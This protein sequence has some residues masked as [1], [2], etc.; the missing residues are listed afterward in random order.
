MRSAMSGAGSWDEGMWRDRTTHA[1]NASDYLTFPVPT[2][3][4]QE[5]VSA[6]VRNWINSHYNY[7]AL[8]L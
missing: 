6:A 2:T 4:E 1:Q 7:R 8:E 3:S 5:L